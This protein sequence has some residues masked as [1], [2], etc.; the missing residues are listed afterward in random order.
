MKTKV[1]VVLLLLFI[2]FSSFGCAETA[3]E[4]E[5]QRFEFCYY[6]PDPHTVHQYTL[7]RNGDTAFFS[8]QDG[9]QHLSQNS[10]QFEVNLSAIDDAQNIIKENKLH[11]WNGWDKKGMGMDFDGFS[12]TVIYDDGQIDDC[13]II[14]IKVP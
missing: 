10:I 2:C 1:F 14:F 3:P 13:N 7:E 4:G 11:S 12:L 8:Y 6:V 5:I 9:E